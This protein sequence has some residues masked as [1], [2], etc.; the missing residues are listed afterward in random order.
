MSQASITRRK[1][2]LTQSQFARLMLV[3]RATVS[4]WE[5]DIVPP[6]GPAVQLMSLFMT[7]PRE[8]IERILGETGKAVES[9]T[10]T[11]TTNQ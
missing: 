11:E 5:N 10:T 1:L 3:D 8:Q 2:G 6:G 4:R 9:E 7:M